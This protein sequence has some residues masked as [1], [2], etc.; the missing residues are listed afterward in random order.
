MSKERKDS[1]QYDIPAHGSLGLLA[2][3]DRGLR[4]WREVRDKEKANKGTKK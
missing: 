4:A 2:L 1:Q 3:G